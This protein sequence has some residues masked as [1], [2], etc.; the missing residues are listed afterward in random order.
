M[1][2]FDF[3]II[4]KCCSVDGGRGI[5]PFFSSPPRRIWQLLSAYPRDFAIHCKK[6]ASAGG[7]LGGG[8]GGCWLG[9]GGIDWC[10]ILEWNISHR[11]D[12]LNICTP[13][14]E[15]TSSIT[16]K[17]HN[18]S[19]SQY[20]RPRKQIFGKQIR[21]NFFSSTDLL[22]KFLPTNLRVCKPT[23]YTFYTS[24][25]RWNSTIYHT[26]LGQNTVFHNFSRRIALS[27]CSGLS[28]VGF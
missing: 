4:E 23:F 12:S 24:H 17:S 19:W 20:I 21:P 28:I 9:A 8:G 26:D 1:E 6:N 13:K 10:I 22:Y 25:L 3:V 5:C 18:G 11:V 27:Q 15:Q 2:L 7:Q 14:K 16:F